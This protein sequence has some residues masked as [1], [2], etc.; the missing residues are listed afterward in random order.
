MVVPAHGPRVGRKS[1]PDGALF[2]SPRR[3]WIDDP[4]PLFRLGVAACLRQWGFVLAGESAG[5]VPEPDLGRC[6][7]LVLDLGEAAGWDVGEAS[8]RRARLSGVLVAGKERRITMASLTSVLVR[9][10][11]T[12]DGLAAALAAARASARD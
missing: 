4:N 10:E 5:L 8:L 3:V 6:D 12:Q 1:A 7:I 9:R 11:L 2:S